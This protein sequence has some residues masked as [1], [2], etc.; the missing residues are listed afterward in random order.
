VTGDRLGRDY[1]DIMGGLLLAVIGLAAALYASARYEIG[2]V[3]E[4]GPGMFPMAIGWTLVVLG[5]LVA[6]PAFFRAGT[7]PEF[8]LREFVTIVASILLFALAI[9]RIGVIAA[10]ALLV[11]C[12]VAARPQAKPLES[13]VLYLVITVSAILLF[14]TGLGIPLPLVKWAP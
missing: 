8:E 14:R 11:G 4:M 5:A 9:D 7:L 10:L 12:A 6:V 1:R 2:T 13:V 3:N